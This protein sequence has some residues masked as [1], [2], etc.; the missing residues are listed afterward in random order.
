VHIFPQSCRFLIS[1][2]YYSLAFCG[3]SSDCKLT[4][5]SL[6]SV[7]QPCSVQTRIIRRCQWL[8]SHPAVLQSY[9]SYISRFRRRKDSDD[10]DCL[11]ETILTAVTKQHHIKHR[12]PHER[13]TRTAAREQKV[14]SVYTQGL[15]LA[16]QIGSGPSSSSPVWI[17][18]GICVARVMRGCE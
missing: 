13:T 17:A 5:L 9:F 3:Y 4:G 1:Y 15:Y 14:Y 10:S 16:S 18:S 11:L 12:Q 2:H 6:L 7:L 8:H